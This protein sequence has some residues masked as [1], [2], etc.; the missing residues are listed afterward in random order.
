[1]A[2]TFTDLLYH[3]V[4]S[5]K[6]RRQLL[7]HDLLPELTRVIGGIIRDRKGRLLECN[8]TPN[9]IHLLAVFHQTFTVS[10]MLRDI[11]AT[12]SDWVRR[13]FG[14]TRVFA[15]QEGYSCFTVSGG[16]KND[17]ANYIRRQQIHHHEKTF[18]EEL[19]EILQREGV[20]YDPRFIFD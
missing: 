12:S 9:H 4:F 7:D 3:C 18:E 17:V 13:K 20:S 1:M 15:W 14:R 11:K 19:I 16:N 6:E 10:D 2:S 8:G 5:T